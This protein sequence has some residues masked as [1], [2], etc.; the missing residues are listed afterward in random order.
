[1]TTTHQLKGQQR[2]LDKQRLSLHFQPRLREL[3][4][5]FCMATSIHSVLWFPDEEHNGAEA[6]EELGYPERL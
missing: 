2:L 3:T 5:G 4:D 6:M 1:M